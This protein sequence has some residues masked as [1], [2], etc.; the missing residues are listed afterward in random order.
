MFSFEFGPGLLMLDTR[1][2]EDLEDDPDYAGIPG[3]MQLKSD[4][5]YGLY[6]STYFDLDFGSLSR[7]WGPQGFPGLLVSNWPLNYDQ[8]R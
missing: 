4:A 6:N 5:T 8:R 7:T 1:W 2:L 3:R